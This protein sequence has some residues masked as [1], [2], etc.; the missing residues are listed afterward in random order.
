[1]WKNLVFFLMEDKNDK[2]RDDEEERRFTFCS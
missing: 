2:L 1:M